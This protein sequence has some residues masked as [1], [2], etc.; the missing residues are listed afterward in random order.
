MTDSV[1]PSP[2]LGVQPAFFHNDSDSV[3]FWV[4][5]GDGAIGATVSRYTLHHRY[6]P[7]AQGEDPLQTHRAHLPELEAAVRRRV[8][9]GSI[10]PVMLREFDLR[11]AAEPPNAV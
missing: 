4:R 11:A 1:E 3:R 10:E 8:A 5:I 6:Q 7:N 2:A 9:N